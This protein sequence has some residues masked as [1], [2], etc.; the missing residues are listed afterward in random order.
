MPEI[1]SVLITWMKATSEITDLVGQRITPGSLP[2]KQPM[3]AITVSRLSGPRSSD[4]P[5]ASPIVQVTHWADTWAGARAVAKVVRE[6][7]DRASKIQ[8]GLT[9]VR[10]T[11][12]ND[13]D[14]KDPTT[15]IFVGIWDPF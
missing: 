9:I 6:E 8:S 13:L 3:P 2:D 12:L 4:L 14:V 7:L 15:A 11:H 5:L 10:V 1:E